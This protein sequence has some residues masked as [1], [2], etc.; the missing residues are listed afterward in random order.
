MSS[1]LCDRKIRVKV[2]NE[3]STEKT[4]KAGVPQGSVLGPSLFN[5]YIHDLPEFSK[6]NLALYADDTAIYA[7]SFYAQAAL[8]QN[9]L[10][11]KLLTNYFDDWKLKLNES[12]T[13]LIIFSRKRT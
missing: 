10:H 11:M 9:Q 2:N 13:E 12:K 1:Y 3:L 7:H 6:T 4:I 8:L 5:F